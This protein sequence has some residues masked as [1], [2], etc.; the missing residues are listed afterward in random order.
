[1]L[2]V[3]SFERW[4]AVIWPDMCIVHCVIEL[5]TDCNDPAVEVARVAVY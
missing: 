4:V 3:K 2:T 1:V 5:L